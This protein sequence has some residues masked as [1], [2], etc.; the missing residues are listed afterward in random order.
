MALYAIFLY[1]PRVEI[2]EEDPA[3]ELLAPYERYSDELKNSGTMIASFPLQPVS[4]ATSI[5]P[6]GL[7]DGPFLETTEIVVGFY[8]VE[9]GDVEAALEIA[10]RNPILTQGGGLEVRRVAT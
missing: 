9:A 3:S 4:M 10:R 7:T 6:D 2:D 8:A 5:R 1:A